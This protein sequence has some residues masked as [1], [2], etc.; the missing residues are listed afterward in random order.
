MV[1]ATDK[2]LPPTGIS[3]S[4]SSGESGGGVTD[5]FVIDPQLGI[6]KNTKRLDYE[7]QR[8]HTLKVQ[9]SDNEGRIGNSSVSKLASLKQGLSFLAIYFSC[10]FMVNTVGFAGSD[11]RRSKMCTG[12]GGWGGG[13][14]KQVISLEF[15]RS[16][17]QDH[18]LSC[19]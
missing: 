3:Y 5:L 12:V 7:A 13:G 14:V 18:T 10:L 9:A 8:V 1:L 11:I 19:S 6:L 16:H 4:I 17:S 2:D 15:L